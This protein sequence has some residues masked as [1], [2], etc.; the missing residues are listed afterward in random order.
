M[1]YIMTAINQ[2]WYWLGPLLLISLGVM[3]IAAAVEIFQGT[4]DEMDE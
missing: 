2:S 4:Q 1:E 3:T